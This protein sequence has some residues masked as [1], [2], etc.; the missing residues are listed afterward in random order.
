[1]FVL[2]IICRDAG[3]VASSERLKMQRDSHIF[4]CFT[5]LGQPWIH[6]ACPAGYNIHVSIFSVFLRCWELQTLLGHW[7]GNDVIVLLVIH[8]GPQES[9]TLLEHWQSNDVA[10]LFCRLWGTGGTLNTYVALCTFNDI[11]NPNVGLMFHIWG[12]REIRSDSSTL[13]VQWYCYVFI[14]SEAWSNKEIGSISG[15]LTVSLYCSLSYLRLEEPYIS[16]EYL[17]CN[18]TTTIVRLPRMCL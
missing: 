16:Q 13:E 3:T 6:L 12:V 18:H 14:V 1:M 15:T 4:S 11:T 2:F 8:D 5:R 9:R 7:T 17:A 10:Q